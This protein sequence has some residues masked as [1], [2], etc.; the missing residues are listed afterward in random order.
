M[1][2]IVLMPQLGI[3]EESALLSA[4]HVAKGDEVKEGDKLFTL[5]TG[6][7]TFDVQAEQGGTVLTFWWRKAMR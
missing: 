3:S 1:A 7:A 5:E 2:N 6:K 4:W